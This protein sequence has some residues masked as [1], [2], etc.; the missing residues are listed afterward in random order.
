[1]SH[2]TDLPVWA[3]LLVAFFLVLGSGLTLLG[4]I[5]LVRFES[6]YARVHAPT[7]GTTWGAGAILIASI[8][9][10]TVLQSRPVLHEILITIF[11]V[12]TTPVT[13][14]LLARAALYRDRTEGTPG[15]PKD[16]SGRD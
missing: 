14:M 9:C 4:A 7:L 1:M 3:A 13:L 5:G 16:A 12:V 6:F 8:V 10:F 15:V 2:V 11:V